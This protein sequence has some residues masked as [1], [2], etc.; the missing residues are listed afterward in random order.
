M[1]ELMA[2]TNR[3]A[4]RKERVL[5]RDIFREESSMNIIMKIRAGTAA[6][7]PSVIM[8]GIFSGILFVILGALF[9]ADLFVKGI[10]LKRVL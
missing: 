2:I 10:V 3:N 1:S 9:P 5:F 7:L 8:L 4:E 6:S